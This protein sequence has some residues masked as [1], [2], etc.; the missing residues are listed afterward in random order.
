MDWNFAAMPYGARWRQY[1]RAFHQHFNQLAIPR[2]H[3]I[4][5]EEA[6]AF[7]AKLKDDPAQWVAHLRA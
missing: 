3:P 7:L 6:S 1:R 4:M 2:Y 5:Y